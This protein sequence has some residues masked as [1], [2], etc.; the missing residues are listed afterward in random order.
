MKHVLSISGGGMR[1]IIPARILVE[2]ERR[3]GQP[4]ADSFDLLAGTSTGGI[5]AC[6]TASPDA[7]SAER[8]M[9][10]YYER[11]P[12]IF[13]RSLLRDLYSGRGS[14]HTKYRG[15]AL[16]TELTR[17]LGLHTL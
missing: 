10:F 6:L 7:L 8:A 16:S 11:G 14:V 3:T 17:C 13:Q 15:T 4:I 12:R 2:V 5:L 9:E 1:G